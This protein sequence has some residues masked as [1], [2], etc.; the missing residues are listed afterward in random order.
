MGREREFGSRPASPSPELS[1]RRHAVIG[2][3]CALGRQRRMLDPIGVAEGVGFEPTIRF[4]V[5]TLSKRAPSA[6]RPSLRKRLGGRNIAAPPKVTTRAG[7]HDRICTH[8]N[9][10][11]CDTEIDHIRTKCNMA[12]P[13]R[14]AHAGQCFGAATAVHGRSGPAGDRAIVAH[15]QLC[16]RHPGRTDRCA[17][18]RR[19]RAHALSRSRGRDRRSQCADGAAAGRGGACRLSAAVALGP[20]RILGSAVH[21][22]GDGDRADHA[23]R[24]DHRRADAADHRGSLGRIPRRARRHGCRARSA[25][26]RPDLG[27]AASAW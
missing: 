1:A 23:G 3:S 22:A 20:A 26:S 27:C 17:A 8:M 2:D 19:G 15:G 18:R 7:S 6:T 24:A 25:A 13:M 12:Q 5:Y 11:A 21:A 9:R 16:S 10:Y 4:P 14:C